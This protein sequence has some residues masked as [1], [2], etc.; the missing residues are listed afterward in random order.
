[1]TYSG[2]NL[3]VNNTSTQGTSVSVNNDSRARSGSEISAGLWPDIPPDYNAE[4]DGPLLV[5]E[6]PGKVW[7]WDG[8][9]W[10]LQFHP[11]DNPGITPPPRGKTGATGPTGPASTIPGP[12]GPVG[13]SGAGA[14]GA[15]GLPGEEGPAGATGPAG[16]AICE[17]VDSM[18]D[19]STR[20]K[21]FIDKF[22]QIYVAL[23]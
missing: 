10:V 13:P 11:G 6:V 19:T 17:N 22:N 2:N 21:L 20:G 7:V 3:E 9:K 16:A 15:S 8:L 1:M 5:E 12:R 18:N 14:T 23:G 4:E